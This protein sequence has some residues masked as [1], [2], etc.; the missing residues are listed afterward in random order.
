MGIDQSLH[1]FVQFRGTDR[2][3]AVA[4]PPV[5]EEHSIAQ[6][7]RIARLDLRNAFD[8]ISAPQG[9]E[10]VPHPPAPNLIAA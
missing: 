7:Q 9:Q 6:S 1:F 8:R 10:R 4:C 5:L 3:V 2:L